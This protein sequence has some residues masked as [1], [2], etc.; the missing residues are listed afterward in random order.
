M[1]SDRMSPPNHKP[2]IPNVTP[3]P[4]TSDTQAYTLHPAPY[5]LHPAPYTLHLRPQ[6]LGPNVSE[7]S[8]VLLMSVARTCMQA[9][10]RRY[11]GH[12]G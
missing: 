9:S 12:A 5:T 3:K 2:Q 11:A 1:H 4:Q 6:D 8:K 7:M 10:L